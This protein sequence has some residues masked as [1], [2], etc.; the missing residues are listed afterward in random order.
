LGTCLPLVGCL[1]T[2]IKGLRRHC[3]THISGREVP[4][5]RLPN[6]SLSLLLS[7]VT[8]GATSQSLTRQL[9]QVPTHSSASFFLIEQHLQQVK[10]LS[11]LL[12]RLQRGCSSSSKIHASSHYWLRPIESSQLGFQ[13]FASYFIFVQIFQIDFSTL[14]LILSASNNFRFIFRIPNE[15]FSISM[16]L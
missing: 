14:P 8:S 10:L 2:L 5:A 4:C 1:A 3:L 11:Q 6:H 9:L 13:N 15:H 16:M 7:R 12:L